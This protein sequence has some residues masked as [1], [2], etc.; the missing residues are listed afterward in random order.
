LNA[1]LLFVVLMRRGH[2][3]FDRASLRHAGLTLLVSAVLGVGLAAAAWRLEAEFVPSAGI[4]RQT[5][6][7]LLL[8]VAGAALYFTLAHLS[9]AADLRALFC[10]LRRRSAVS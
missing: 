9:G 10:L 6:A 1:A 8:I 5:A 4:L 3:P 2:W 7:L